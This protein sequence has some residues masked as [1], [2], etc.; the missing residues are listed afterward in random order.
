[1]FA[2]ENLGGKEYFTVGSTKDQVIHAQG[3]PD[4]FTETSFTYGTSKVY[5]ENGK[6]K[7]WHVR[8]TP[9]NVRLQPKSNVGERTHFTVG[10]TR[11]EV[12]AAQGTPDA[13]TDTEF[14]YG[15][16]RVYFDKGRV[17]SWQHGSKKLNARSVIS[18]Q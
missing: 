12:L 16:S 13:F 4:S 1:M 10:S 8:Y 6:V 15:T 7:S 9:L 11:D 5:F 18:S 2:A 14:S 17:Q 3:T